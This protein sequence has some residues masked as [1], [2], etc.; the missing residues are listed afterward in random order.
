MTQLALGLVP[1]LASVLLPSSAS[2]EHTAAPSSIA[3]PQG[4]ILHVDSAGP[5]R[6]LSADERAAIYGTLSTEPRITPTV[7]VVNAVGPSVVYIETDTTQRVNHWMTGTRDVNTR[8][9]G[10]GVVVHEGGFIVTNYHVVKGA[11]KIQVSFSDD[12]EPFPAD[13]LSYKESE[14]LALLLIRLTPERRKTL[15]ALASQNG[16]TAEARFPAVRMGKSHDL[17]PGERVIA[18][19]NPHGQAHTVSTGIVSGLHRQVQVQNLVF[20][21]LIQTDASINLGNS[22]GPLLNVRGELIGINTVM[23]LNAENIGFAIPVDRVRETLAEELFPNAR[24]SW[25]GLELHPGTPLIVK[26]VW[27]GGPADLAMICEGDLLISLGETELTTKQA[28]LDASLLLQPQI[29]TLI[30]VQR[31]GQDETT[32][33]VP[34]DHLDGLLFEKVGVVAREQVIT[35]D[36]YLIIEIV[37]TGSPA[38]QLGLKPGDLIPAIRPKAPGMLRALRIRDRRDLAGVIEHLAVGTSIA[39]DVYRDLNENG[40]FEQNELLKGEFRLR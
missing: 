17:M 36:S 14:D 34:W 30:R 6:R 3:L 26:R 31:S 25:L 13:L 33:L 20:R 32:S 22:G 28:F 29:P 7:R 4:S 2:S 11:H 15:N 21:D 27:P 10:T 38:D 24:T 1:L 35:R 16:E 8:G 19:G 40:N 5:T 9:G 18:I 39:V 12:L 37:A 23:N